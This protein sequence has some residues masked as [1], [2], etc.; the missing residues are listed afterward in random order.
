MTVFNMDVQYALNKIHRHTDMTPP[1]LNTRSHTATRRAACAPEVPPNDM[2]GHPEVA[3]LTTVRVEELEQELPA[4]EIDDEEFEYGMH[5]WLLHLCHDYGNHGCR[6]TH[7]TC[8]KAT[9]FGDEDLYEHNEYLAG[10][11]YFEEYN[12]DVQPNTLVSA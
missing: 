12:Q 5:T 6:K 3:T 10:I 4:V 1:H 2:W 9:I 8:Y 7:R 11:A